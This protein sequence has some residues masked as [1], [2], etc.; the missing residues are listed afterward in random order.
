MYVQ[1]KGEEPAENMLLKFLIAK[2][3][4]NQFRIKAVNFYNR[5]TNIQKKW[6]GVYLDKI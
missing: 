6:R 3:N 1:L 5:M 2:K 4:I